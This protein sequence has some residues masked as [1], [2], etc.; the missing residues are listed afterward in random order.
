MT[1]SIHGLQ[2]AQRG[3]LNTIAT[4]KPG[5]AFEDAI[6]FATI[7]AQRYAVTITHVDTGA[8]RAS[9]RI[10]L[11]SPSQGPRGV[12]FIQPGTL[13]SGRA[14]P[15]VYGFFENARGGQHAF[16]GRVPS[17]RGGQIA[18]Q[19]TNAMLRSWASANT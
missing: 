17:E 7:E 16:Y 2:E 15:A 5:G 18:R 12:V 4:M 10:K 11:E 6:R 8:L 14:E 19:A 13:R 9:H 1:V 3:L